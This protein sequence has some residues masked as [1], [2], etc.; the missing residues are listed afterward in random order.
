MGT[1]FTIIV[2]LVTIVFAVILGAVAIVWLIVVGFLIWMAVAAIFRFFDKVSRPT[3][4]G[5]GQVIGRHFMPE[6]EEEYTQMIGEDTFNRTRTV[7]DCWTVKVRLFGCDGTLE[8]DQDTYNKLRVD[9]QVAVDYRLG[10][11]SGQPHMYDVRPLLS[12]VA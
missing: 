9:D 1:F 12:A 2:W 11:F 6:H 7:P 5:V 3:I 8:V 4:Q 10:R